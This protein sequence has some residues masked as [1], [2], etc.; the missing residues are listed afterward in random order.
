MTRRTKSFL[1][2]IQLIWNFQE[3]V[4]QACNFFLALI[5][6][7]L[8]ATCHFINSEYASYVVGRAFKSYAYGIEVYVGGSTS[9][10][11]RL[12]VAEMLYN[13]LEIYN[14]LCREE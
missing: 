11:K 6:S 9:L 1:K 3:T 7:N 12:L 10:R 8:L 2:H 13:K 14:H 5:M 4:I